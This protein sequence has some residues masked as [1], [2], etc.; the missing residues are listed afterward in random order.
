M[1]NTDTIFKNLKAIPE[2]LRIFGFTENADAYVYSTDLVDGQFNMTVTVS[3]EGQVSAEVME[4]ASGESY[5]L[6]R[7]P[8]A[9]G[10]FVG[11]VRDEY[12]RVLRIIADA[13]CE[14][15][16]FKSEGA[17]QVIRYVREKYHDELEFLWERFPGNAIFRRQDNA[18]WYAALLIVQKGKLK[19]SGDG[20]VEILDLRMRP[21]GIDA[22][23]DGRIYFPGYHMN[24]KHWVT[25][26]LDGSVPEEEIFRRIDESFALAAT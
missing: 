4:S 12:E 10:A 8:G 15:D 14:R 17:R 3:K 6:H 26:C 9:A 16:V 25:V 19:L 5:V 24:K 7:V 13:C 22:L 18:K 20:L 21:E 2:Q 11:R 23:V 1:P